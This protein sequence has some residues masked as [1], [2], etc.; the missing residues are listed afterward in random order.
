M[1]RRIVAVGPMKLAITFA[2]IQG[3]MALVMMI[4]DPCLIN[5]PLLRIG[6]HCE[7]GYDPARLARYIVAPAARP[8]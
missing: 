6:S 3:G 2:I 5:A 1:K 4:L 7:F 8:H